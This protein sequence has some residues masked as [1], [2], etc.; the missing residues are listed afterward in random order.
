MAQGDIYEQLAKMIDEEDTVGMPAT[1]A[2]L[3]LLRI[4]YTPEEAELSL[5]IRLS[6]GT[7][8][9][10]AVKTG[11]DQSSLKEKLL[12]M[13]EKGIIIYDPAEEDPVY[14]AVGMTAGGLTE[15]GAWG[16][17]RFPYS[18]ELIKAMHEVGEDHAEGALAKLGFP[19]TP[20]WAGLD[21]L[22][23]DARP[24]ENL[25]EAVK[26]AGHWSVSLCP[27]RMG[28][29]M[30][31]PEDPCQHIMETCVHTGALSRWA[32]KHH[33]AR[34]LTYDELVEVLRE[35]N[36]DGLVHTINIFGLIC[37]CCN[38]CCPI[39]HTYQMGA[40]TFIPSPF[41]ARADS[42]TCI[43]CGTCEER[44]PVNAITV[45]A[46]AVVDPEKCLGC[47]VCVPTCT[48]ESIKLVRRPEDNLE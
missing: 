23:D 17:V 12:Q 13:A 27:C 39:F 34:E 43:A 45:D 28:R 29:A 32:V 33:M 25:A 20:V 47:G 5:N 11:I 37:N 30:V 14:R 3:K 8:S 7:L 38:D 41:V 16:G 42:S 46:F 1:P 9:E 44:C 6:G 24:E 2:F 31:T 22:P 48:E 19:Y 18:V 40:P 10:L 21:A 36:R 15:T 4:Q 26:E 35:T